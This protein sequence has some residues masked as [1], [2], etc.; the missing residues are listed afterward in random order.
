MD[1][2]FFLMNG[3]GDWV[4]QIAENANLAASGMEKATSEGGPYWLAC[5]FPSV[6]EPSSPASKRHRVLNRGL[7]RSF[8]NRLILS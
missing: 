4:R 1:G 3:L 7:S 6:P 2:N 8:R 5:S